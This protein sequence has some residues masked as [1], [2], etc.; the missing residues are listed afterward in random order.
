[1][2]TTVDIADDLLERA[3]KIARRERITLKE[4]LIEG[5]R[6]EIERRNK[7]AAVVI[8]PHVVKGEDKATDPSW[9]LLRDSL[10]GHEGSKFSG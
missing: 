5:L 1:M 6:H 7:H 9:D 2:K 10:Y 4:L 3:R 8:H